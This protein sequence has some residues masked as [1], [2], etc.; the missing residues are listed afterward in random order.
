MLRVGHNSTHNTTQKGGSMT[1]E[2]ASTPPSES[3]TSDDS[4]EFRVR[5]VALPSQSVNPSVI[6]PRNKRKAAEPRRV[7]AKKERWQDEAAESDTASSG[8][9]DS[10][11]GPSS[12]SDIKCNDVLDKS[13][14][15]AKLKQRNYKNMT[16]ERRIEANARERTRVHTISAAFDN[17]RR[18]VPAYSC[19]QKLSKLAILRI[20]CSYILAL[21]SLNDTDYSQDQDSPSFPDCVDLCTRTIQNEGRARRRKQQHLSLI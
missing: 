14:S 2:A 16:R 3:G 18:A 20:A 5:P 1:E 6:R 17:L 9:C 8:E 7:E 21:A 15:R 19:N 4:V 11:A 13:S 12:R 10:V